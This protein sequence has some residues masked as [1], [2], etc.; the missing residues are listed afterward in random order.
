MRTE[1]AEAGSLK[2]C[3]SLRKPSSRGLHHIKSKAAL[4]GRTIKGIVLDSTGEF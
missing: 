2:G 1:L 3:S 4:Q